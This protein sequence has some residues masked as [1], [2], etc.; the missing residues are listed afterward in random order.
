MQYRTGAYLI[1]PAAYEIRRGGRLLATEPQVIELLLLLIANRNRVVSKDEIIAAIWHN[2][3][4][5]DATLNSRIKAARHVLGDDGAAQQ[6]I[7]TVHGRGFRFIGQ[8][9]ELS[10]AKHAAPAGVVP[11][12]SDRPSLV[13]MPFDNLSGAADAHFVDGVVEEITSALSRVR[14]FFVIARQSAFAY[15]GRFVD[16]REVGKELA[17]TYV[18]EGTVRRGQGRV[19]IS[20]Q[21]VDANSRAQLWSQRY[22]GATTDIF[23]FQDRIAAQVAG[24]IHPAV[25]KAEIEL[26]KAKPPNSLKAYEFVLRAYPDLWS[27][28]Q[29]RNQEAI[30]LLGR[31]LATD[32]GYGRAHALL[33]WCL[34]QEVA[35]FWCQDPEQI[36]ARALGAVAAAG[37]SID[38]D[39]TA[40]AAAGAALSQCGDQDRAAAYIERAL[41]L[42]HNNA[43]A[44]ARYGW[45]A[46]YR[47][48]PASASQRFER[49]LTLS[50]FDPL[51]FNTNIG[52]ASGLAM[53]GA[54]GEALA[55]VRDVVNKHPQVTSHHR[56][57]AALAAL[58]GDLTM[59][60]E[61]VAQI[62]RVHPSASLAAMRASH[63]MRH[64]T[65]YFSKLVEGLRQ[66]GLPET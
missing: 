58:A 23:D 13:V 5:S 19:R 51:A 62:L 6:L 10:G 44:W 20:V 63:P 16:V 9:E 28:N 34:A 27:Q 22:E 18:V 50:P 24:A 53:R 42:D 12:P 38:D 30:A 14:D 1:D 46:L 64:L 26:A 3:A 66:A 29:D 17:V 40:L 55:I 52:I 47:D 45:L 7:R 35:Y 41:A 36:R 43:W 57:L 32:P 25:R 56:L 2:R 4:I 37:T 48:D 15:K 60:R 54:Y 49:A 21:L 8:V 61:T 39:P 11:P 59:A 31:A 33:A 65:H